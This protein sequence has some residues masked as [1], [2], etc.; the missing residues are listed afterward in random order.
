M[1]IYTGGLGITISHELVHKN[2][3]VEQWLG[4]EASWLF[5]VVEA[6]RIYTAVVMVMIMMICVTGSAAFDT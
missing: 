4:E 2:N 5:F 6:R 1:G 3:R